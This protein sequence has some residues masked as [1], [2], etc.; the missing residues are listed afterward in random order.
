[1][2]KSVF[3]SFLPCDVLH[4]PKKGLAGPQQ[5]TKHTIVAMGTGV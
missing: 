5:K 3:P 4:I 1:M 2:V